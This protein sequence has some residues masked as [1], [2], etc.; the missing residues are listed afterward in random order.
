MVTPISTE[1]YL[2]NDVMKGNKYQTG[3][4]LNELR[5]RVA[6]IHNSEQINKMEMDRKATELK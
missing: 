3:K 5:D 4:K 1:E 6:K 2:R